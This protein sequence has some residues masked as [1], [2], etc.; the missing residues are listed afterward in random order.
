MDTQLKILLLEDNRSDAEM[1]RRVLEK[2]QVGTEFRLEMN[3][4]GFL[5]ALEAFTPDVIVSD[6]SL[7]QFSATEALEIVHQ[8]C[9]HLPFILVTG[10]VSEEFAAGI[11]K[12]GAD[13]Y[14]LKDRLTRLPAAIENALKQKR[15][16]KEKQLSEENLK[17]IFENTSEGFLLIDRNCTVKAFNDNGKKYA[18][19]HSDNVPIAGGDV[20]D[21]VG[22]A[23]KAVM[24]AMLGR[25]MLGEKIQY[26]NSYQ[27]NNTYAIEIAGLRKE[28]HGI[29]KGKQNVIYDPSKSQNRQ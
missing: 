26:N 2:E 28:W 11:I 7:P 5:A 24:Q 17:A 25:V 6:N 29:L 3:R 23:N 16:E 18:L 1:I 13:D 4:D 9:L 10:T 12:L 22:A 27:E 15:I 8:R 21:F 19:Y 14:I 20:F